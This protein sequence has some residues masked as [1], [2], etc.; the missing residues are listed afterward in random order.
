MIIYGI[1]R[2]RCL[3]ILVEIVNEVFIQLINLRVNLFCIV[4][5]E[6]KIGNN[7][8]G[9]LDKLCVASITLIGVNIGR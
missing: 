3:G 2:N 4:G 8:I 7:K 5:M 1:K 9:C 6:I